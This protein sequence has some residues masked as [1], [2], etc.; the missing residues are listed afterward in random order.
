MDHSI[1]KKPE[2]PKLRRATSG[3]WECISK[4]RSAYAPEAEEALSLWQA[5]GQPHSGT[6]RA[7]AKVPS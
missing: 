5:I 1:K 3:G 6:R 7:T 2:K 4:A